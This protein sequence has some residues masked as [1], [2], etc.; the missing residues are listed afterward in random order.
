M[1][2]VG[3][4]ETLQTL[5][6]YSPTWL[7]S[8]LQQALLHVRVSFVRKAFWC[9]CLVGV[10]RLKRKTRKRSDWRHR[11]NFTID[12]VVM[13]AIHISVSLSWMI[14]NVFPP[15]SS[16]SSPHFTQNI[17]SGPW[18]LLLNTHSS[19]RY[20]RK[21][22]VRPTKKYTRTCS[23]CSRGRYFHQISSHKRLNVNVFRFV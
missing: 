10:M 9:N 13:I 7:G 6:C 4:W 14:C 20:G 15:L 11:H 16:F 12:Q 23:R 19:Q 1:T 3:R 2:S 18:E 5:D 21:G 17:S 22:Q 8:L